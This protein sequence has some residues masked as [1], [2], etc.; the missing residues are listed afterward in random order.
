MH[1]L[2]WMIKLSFETTSVNTWSPSCILKPLVI[3][4]QP[5]EIMVNQ[6]L[7]RFMWK[8]FG[9]LHKRNFRFFNR[10]LTENLD[11][12]VSDSFSSPKK[13]TGVYFISSWMPEND[14][15]MSYLSW[16]YKAYWQA[17]FK[18]E[19][20]SGQFWIDILGIIFLKY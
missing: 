16:L 19:I 2:C 10:R 18:P 3:T 12:K 1:K 11:K 4:R 6:N 9:P 8:L 17:A 20:M 5:V 13:R 7:I 15:K 14:P